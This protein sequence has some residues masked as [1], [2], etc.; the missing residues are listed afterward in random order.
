MVIG[1]Y[2]HLGLFDGQDLAILS[3]RGGLRVHEQALGASQERQVDIDNPLIK[4]AIAYYQ[5]ASYGF[6]QHL[7]EWA[8][9]TQVAAAVK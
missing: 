2:Q 9:Q 4:R 5:S 7:L 1:N 3:P 8:P 6:T